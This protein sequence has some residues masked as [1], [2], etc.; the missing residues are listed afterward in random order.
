MNRLNPRVKNW[1]KI[2][3]AHQTLERWKNMWNVFHRA[4]IHDKQISNV[5]FNSLT[6]IV[7]VNV[8]FAIM[9]W[10]PLLIKHK[11]LTKCWFNFGPQT[12]IYNTAPTLWKMVLFCF[13]Y[14]EHNFLVWKANGSGCYHTTGA[15]ALHCHDCG[16]S[17]VPPDGNCADVH[18]GSFTSNSSSVRWAIWFT[19]FSEPHDTT[20]LHECPIVYTAPDSPRQSPIQS[21]T[22]R[23]VA[24][25][26][27]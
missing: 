24:Q 18:W 25:L 11:M 23:D 7:A 27:W 15:I 1:F 26:Q 10:T 4:W 5:T 16:F 6:V 8:F 9:E 22:G 13:I 14:T 3:A 19:W 20:W 2:V 17:E 12:T 21:W